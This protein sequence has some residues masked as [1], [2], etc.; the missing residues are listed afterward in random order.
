MFIQ[1]LEKTARSP[2]KNGERQA[3]MQ[4][5]GFFI[6]RLYIGCVDYCMHPFANYVIQVVLQSENLKL[7]K[8]KII[9]QSIV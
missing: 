5:L 2:T 6:R 3:A 9:F 4:L 8:E 1:S 7:E